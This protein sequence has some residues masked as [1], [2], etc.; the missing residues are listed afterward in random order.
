MQYDVTKAAGIVVLR[1]NI[2][3]PTKNNPLIRIRIFWHPLCFNQLQGPEIFS[4]TR[5]GCFSDAWKCNKAF[6]IF[7]Q[8]NARD[9]QQG[10]REESSRLGLM[11]V[12][13]LK[14]SCCMLAPADWLLMRVTLQRVEF[15]DFDDIFENCWASFSYI[16]NSWTIVEIDF[17]PIGIKFPPVAAL[18]T[19]LF[20]ALKALFP[21]IFCFE[22]KSV[23]FM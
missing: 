15:S 11:I 4:G 21:E 3:F 17:L 13:N 5:D 12:A 19:P 9:L 22:Q 14:F 6:A 7:S 20:S 8:K 1:R 23:L 2:P 10:M 16:F 18:H